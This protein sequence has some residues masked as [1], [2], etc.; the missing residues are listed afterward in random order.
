M[1]MILCIWRDFINFFVFCDS[2]PTHYCQYLLLELSLLRYWFLM[3]QLIPVFSFF[4][5]LA[6]TKFESEVPSS[7]IHKVWCVL[8][9]L[10]PTRFSL[11]RSGFII[12]VTMSRQ[13]VRV[14]HSWL[15]PNAVTDPSDLY[16]IKINRVLFPT[17]SFVSKAITTNSHWY[18][19]ICDEYIYIHDLEYVN[20]QGNM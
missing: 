2:L 15:V 6:S 20:I 14:F 13:K 9:Q 19:T 4:F 17:Y 10:V 12:P 18:K 3:T 7:R 11:F 16:T 8:L 5:F 1:S